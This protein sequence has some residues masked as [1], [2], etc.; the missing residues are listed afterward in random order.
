MKTYFRESDG[1]DSL[2]RPR[3]LPGGQCLDHLGTVAFLCTAA[4]FVICF[5]SGRESHAGRVK[6]RAGLGF[7]RNL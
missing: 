6:S 3:Q 1:L 5:L 4:Q 2:C 7:A